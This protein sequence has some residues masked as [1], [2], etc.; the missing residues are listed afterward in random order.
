GLAPTQGTALFFAA[1]CFAAGTRITTSAG[2]RPVETLRV[3]DQV[4]TA[5]GALRTVRWLGYRS[6]ELRRH[7]RPHD[8]MPVRV[9]RGA[10]APGCPSRDLVLSP[11]HALFLDGVLIPVRYLLNGASIAQQAAERITWWHVELDRHDVILAEGLPAESYLDT[12]NRDAF[13]NA[14]PGHAVALHPDFARGIWRA[15]ACAALATDGPALARVRAR[16]LVRL[17]RLGHAVTDDP[18]LRCEAGGT[19]LAPQLFGDW[20]C[21]A[22]PD[23]CAALRLRS[24]TFQPAA[25]AV[26]GSDWRTLGVALRALCIDGVDMPLD[27]AAFAA[28]WHPAEPGLRWSDGDA[29]LRAPSG[30]VVEFRL[31][32]LARYVA[33]AVPGTRAPGTVVA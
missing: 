32:R 14:G 9:Q 2:D 23:H 27:S 8:V 17:P 24:R 19:A 33:A 3:G 26:S 5:C 15:E 21:I 20:W 16:L 11:D 13:A 7:P 22:M 18:G 29:M 6:V 31:A 28:G 30:S 12:G 1:A 10:V 25:L 4:R